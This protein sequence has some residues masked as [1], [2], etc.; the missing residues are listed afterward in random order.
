MGFASQVR[1]ITKAEKS[2]RF[3][4]LGLDNAG[5]STLLAAA[6]GD[7]IHSI[8]PTAGFRISTHDAH[9]LLGQPR[10][11][12]SESEPDP[13]GTVHLWDIGGQACLRSFWSNYYERSSGILFVVDA[14]VSFA[15]DGLGSQQVQ[16]ALR[17][18]Q[19]FAEIR[20]ILKE[21]ADPTSALAGVPLLIALNKCD[22][23]HEADALA[24]TV[25]SFI[26]T[27]TA[28]TVEESS[29]TP[30][31]SSPVTL[32]LAEPPIGLVSV[33]AHTGFN[34]HAAFA[35]LVAAS[36]TLQRTRVTV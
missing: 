29:A 24:A 33:S 14:S 3:L 18:D 30:P 7:D 11:T 28:A 12:V 5:K 6:L 23:G 32:L 9:R 36:T 2:H 35:W 4:I 21:Q 13:L 19:W 8:V 1:K 22:H 15:P 16:L 26:A 20:R 27:E 34:V 31:S 25:R 10:G 17:K